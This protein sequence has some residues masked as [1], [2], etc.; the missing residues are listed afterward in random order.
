MEEAPKAR[1]G[2][3]AGGGGGERQIRVRHQGGWVSG[4]PGASLPHA[5]LLGPRASQVDLD[6]RQ[7]GLPGGAVLGTQ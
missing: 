4:L 5:K 2:T 7:T 1:E 6:F 3:E